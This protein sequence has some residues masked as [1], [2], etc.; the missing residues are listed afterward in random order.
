MPRG[1]T[2]TLFFHLALCATVVAAAAAKARTIN[3][4]NA[5]AKL[6][7]IRRRMFR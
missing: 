2:R 1:T 5:S 6:G 4:V 3:I 7:L